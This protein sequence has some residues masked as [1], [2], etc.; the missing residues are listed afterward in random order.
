MYEGMKKYIIWPLLSILSFI[1]LIE[2]ALTAAGVDPHPKGRDFIVNRA[3]DYPEAFLKDH[4]LFWRLR[5]GRTIESEFFEGRSYRINRQGFRGDDFRLEKQ[6]LRV[7][8]LGNSCSFGWGIDEG[9]TFADR[10]QQK[11]RA[12]ES[13][14]NAE[15][16]NFSVP[17]YTSFQGA[18]NYRRNV[19]P[20]KPDILIVTFGWNDQWL[21]ANERPDKAQEMPPRIV[22][23]VYNA[24]STL[25]FY[26]W[27]KGLLLPGW[28]PGDT[29]S[30]SYEH[31]RVSLPDFK[32]NLGEIIRMA[33]QDGARV[34]LLT[35]PMPSPAVYRD[36]SRDRFTLEVHSHYNDM[37][38]EAAATFGTVL[39]D[40]AALFDRHDNLFDDPNRDPYHY[41]SRGHAL[42]A[43]ELLPVLL[44]LQ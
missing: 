31:T 14:E 35:S 26:R 15:V 38:Q 16:Y 11:L 40:L 24:I 30:F 12:L 19:R 21:S 43:D 20:Y 29:V 17:G 10:L 42:A 34:I 5:P 6:G 39:V 22:L 27:F 3:P 1:F 36:L 7:A 32:K 18:I 37:T 23:D 41:N 25:R 33:R 2:F 8:V 13:T 28:S 4:D 44:T 9:E